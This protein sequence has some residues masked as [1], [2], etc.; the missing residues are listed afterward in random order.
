ML[1]EKFDKAKDNLY[2]NT[3]YPVTKDGWNKYLVSND[4]DLFSNTKDM[5]IY[6][7]I[8]FCNSL[9]KFCEY[10]RFKKQDEFT[11][12][13]YI[14]ILE[15]Q[16][17]E[18]FNNHNVNKLYGFDIGGGTPTCL[19]DNNFDRLLELEDK[20]E[21]HFNSFVGDY[22]KSIEA[23]FPTITENKIK[24]IV[25]HN[26]KRISLGV[27]VANCNIL[28]HN[29][30]NNGTY[31]DMFDKINLMK[32]LGIRK[33]NLDFMYG[34]QGQ[35]ICDVKNSLELISY[36]NSDQVT[37]YEMRYNMVD[38]KEN[39]SRDEMLKQ[40]ETFYNGLINLGYIGKFG[41]NTFSRYNDDGVSSYLRYRMK[42]C[43]PYKG[44]GIS[45]Q[46]MSYKGLSY[47][48]GK[49]ET[50]YSKCIMQNKISEQFTYSL[51]EKEVIA[52]YIAISLYYGSFDIDV[53][54]EILE[55]HNIK[56]TAEQ[57]YHDQLK[58][59]LENE[60]VEIHNQIVTLTKKG[61]KYYGAVGSV[62]YPN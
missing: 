60:C 34:L 19:S 6:I 37:L 22:E 62:F 47:N 51:P 56:E 55:F 43:T 9:C 4:F 30:R 40:Y 14:S 11:E 3:S 23:N 31:S 24:A 49:G 46:S 45:A 28:N 39:N 32:Y 26:I 27:Q 48:M 50:E 17:N 58:F 5:S 52:K 29:M 61:F 59:L 20:I 18:F 15:N 21:S 10:T 7:H 16:I 42:S 36:L 35:N 13:Q 54:N 38:Q 8:P 2:Y 41:C 25:S 44:F 33:I 1:R 12:S 57:L 53:L